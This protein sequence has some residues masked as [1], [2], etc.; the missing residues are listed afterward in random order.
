MNKAENNFPTLP[1]LPALELWDA[2]HSIEQIMQATGQSR[3]TVATTLSQY[4]ENGET[5]QHVINM[6][7]GSAMLAAR[8]EQVR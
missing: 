6:K 2:G 1:K 8:L 4:V 7:R 3:H 5:V